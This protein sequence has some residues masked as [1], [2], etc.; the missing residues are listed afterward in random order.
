MSPPTPQTKKNK[1]ARG[2]PSPPK[3]QKPPPGEKGK[4]PPSA[5]RRSFRFRRRFGKAPEN[6][7]YSASAA[8]ASVS[9]VKSAVFIKPNTVPSTTTR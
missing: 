8:A 6:T 1:G 4:N 3:K 2:R 9:A 5:G 7:F